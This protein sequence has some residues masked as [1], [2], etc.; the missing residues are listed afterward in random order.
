MK[1]TPLVIQYE[2]RQLRKD[3]LWIFDHRLREAELLG[4]M[5]RVASPVDDT[6]MESFW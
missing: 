3:T 1:V 5:G 4:S 2:V 6:M